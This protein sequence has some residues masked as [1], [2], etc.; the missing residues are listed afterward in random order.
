MG[1]FC[2]PMGRIMYVDEK[3]FRINAIASGYSKRNQL[4]K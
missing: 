3:R 4:S 2:D 1:A